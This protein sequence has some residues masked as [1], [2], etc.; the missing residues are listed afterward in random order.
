[1]SASS[2][3]LSFWG[4]FFSGDHCFKIRRLNGLG[5]VAVHGVVG[6][7]L[8]ATGP[9]VL[10]LVSWCLFGV[11]SLLQLDHKGSAVSSA[12]LLTLIIMD[13]VLI[14]HPDPHRT[15]RQKFSRCFY[16]KWR[17]PWLELAFALVFSVHHT[18]CKVRLHQILVVGVWKS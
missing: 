12:T 8:D 2:A 9:G 3:G 7:Q 18:C 13:W 15:R 14:L 11:V 6:P 1:M 17:D 5:H 10:D 4:R 16:I